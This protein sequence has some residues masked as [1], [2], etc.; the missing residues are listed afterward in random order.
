[1][2]GCESLLSCLSELKSVIFVILIS[3]FFKEL[4]VGD[5][6][7]KYIQFAVSLFL[8]SFLLSTLFRTDFSLPDIPRE[9]I[10][11][12]QQNLLQ[13]EFSA[14]IR[15]EIEKNLTAQKISYHEIRVQLSDTYELES[16]VIVTNESR[17]TIQQHLKGDF[18]Y[19]VVCPTEG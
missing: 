2:K 11:P 19:E 5:R 1:M 4:L 3:E 17:E 8:F 18:P 15:E 9:F 10:Y 12:T 7:R 16:V 13:N 14:T 6:F